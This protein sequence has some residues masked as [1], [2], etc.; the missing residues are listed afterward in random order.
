MD[1]C[2]SKGSGTPRVIP[3]GQVRLMVTRTAG[4][5]QQAGRMT[6][7]GLSLPKNE[8]LRRGAKNLAPSSATSGWPGDLLN[9]IQEYGS[10][11]MPE[12]L[13]A[14]RVMQFYSFHESRQCP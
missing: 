10:L 6:L 14:A 11:K 9:P 13:P 4:S 5:G 12:I 1:V 8:I 3:I 2:P 7:S